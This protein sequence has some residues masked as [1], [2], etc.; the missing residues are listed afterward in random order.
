MEALLPLA[1][2]KQS[3]MPHSPMATMAAEYPYP[4]GTCAAAD[5]SVAS[6]LKAMNPEWRLGDPSS[7][8]GSWIH[9]S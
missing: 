7:Y 1:A 9:C 8:A 4:I 3:T 2:P 5:C 6:K